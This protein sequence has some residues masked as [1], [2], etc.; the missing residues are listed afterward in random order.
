MAAPI[1]AVAPAAAAGVALAARTW[2]YIPYTH[3]STQSVSVRA[4]PLGVQQGC[5][6]EYHRPAP[7][8]GARGG[9]PP[10]MD[11]MCD[12]LGC[13]AKKGEH[14]TLAHCSTRI[15]AHSDDILMS[16][17]MMHG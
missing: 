5:C 17:Q 3:A 2:F 1:V 8:A 9:A 6:T 11:D 16:T 7:L 14:A 4:I 13:N 10:G 15:L 12:S